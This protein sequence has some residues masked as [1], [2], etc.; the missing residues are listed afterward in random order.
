MVARVLVPFDGDGAGV[1]E[2]T[3]GQRGLWTSMQRT[4]TSLTLSGAQRLPPG[5]TVPLVVAG[6]RFVLNRHQSLRT[7]LRFTAD[8]SPRQELVSSGELPLELIEAGDG[9]PDALAERVR[10][11]YEHTVFDYANEFPIRM[12]LLHTDNVPSHVVV[13]YCHLALD[14]FGLEALLADQ[15]TMDIRT[16][17]ATVP[18][19]GVQ[20]LELARRQAEPA[21]LRQCDAS[22]RYLERLLR[23]MPARRF[24]GG[25]DPRQ[26][27]YWQVGFNSPAALLAAQV[28][29][30]RNRVGTGPVLLA[31]ASMAVA[32]ATG[33][34]PVVLQ[35]LVNNRFRPGFATAVT[36]L[37]Q[38]GVCL[39]PVGGA[40]LDEV[41]AVAARAST[42]AAKNAY[43]D[44]YRSDE[45]I[46]AV[47]RERGEEI[48]LSVFF[49]DR[50]SQVGLPPP[51]RLP[52]R[53]EI[54]AAL[55]RGT[56]RWERPL[57]RFDHALF[58]HVNDVPDAVDV[59]V[60]A[61]THQVG[62]ADMEALVRGVEAVLVESAA[63][64]AV[65]AGTRT[66][67]APA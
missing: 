41:I 11:R 56:L 24:G 9:D 6:L 17:L 66:V 31:A 37:T 7:R 44:P 51:D 22:L 10:D 59:L 57:D 8:G 36:P 3:W 5:T 20:P 15:A 46:A 63:G 67:P 45:L 26:P 34:D 52:G 19:T 2:L 49:N 16:G 4:G 12:A 48:E 27:R 33:S 29:A 64:P 58:I 25:G 38:S 1:G 35:V 55:P 65:V 40:G 39:V 23:Q 28:V 50:R 43:Y 14:A 18:V 21:T 62:P 47:G 13:A 53:A 61:D 32:R 42:R 30:A 60:C 54:E